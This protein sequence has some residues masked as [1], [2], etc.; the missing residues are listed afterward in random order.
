ME[1]ELDIALRERIRKVG[2]EP[3]LSKISGVAQPSINNIKNNRV[4]FDNIR[5]G[6]LRKLFP[7]MQIDFLGTGGKT[8]IEG[9]LIGM[10][11]RLSPE[12]RA[13]LAL[14]IADKYKG[15]VEEKLD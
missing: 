11:N 12:Q 1:K 2:S 3:K 4:A 6:T 8:G 13:D 14:A 7:N 10:I 15:V 9:R 5:M